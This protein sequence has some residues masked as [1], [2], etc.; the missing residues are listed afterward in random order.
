MRQP[1]PWQ[2]KQNGFWY[3]KIAGRQIPLGRDKP[4]AFAEYHRIMADRQSAPPSLPAAVAA[5]PEREPEL[6]VARLLGMFLTWC[7]T[8]RSAGTYGWYLDYLRSFR[9]FI[10]T[11]KPVAALMPGDIEDWVAKRYRKGSPSYQNGACRAVARV[12][13]WALKRRQIAFNPVTGVERPRAEPRVVYITSDQWERIIAAVDPSDPFIDLLTLLRETGCRVNEAKR[14]EARHFKRDI[15]TW[16]FP[17]EESKGKKRAR[18][19]PLNNR[20]LDVTRRLVLKHPTGPL[21]RNSDS[22]PWKTFA[23]ANRFR[24]LLVELGI[25]KLCGTATRHTFI[26]DALKRAVP[27]NVLAEVVGHV[28]GTM[29][30][31]VYGHAACVRGYVLA[32]L[33]LATGEVPPTIK[34]TEVRA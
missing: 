13:N 23:I 30:L 28:N 26:T 8:H 20:A 12:F 33:A 2:R 31:T 9:D 14:V 4:A 29:I 22:T 27:I 34:A 15:E 5:A 11:E 18:V 21:L 10:G 24:W 1:Q 17:K 16:T 3:V 7:E 6:T 32:A 19:V 25:P